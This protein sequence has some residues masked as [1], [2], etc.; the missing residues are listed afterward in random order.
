MSQHSELQD[1]PCASASSGSRRFRRRS[2][3]GLL[4]DEPHLGDAKEEEEPAPGVVLKLAEVSGCD[5]D[6]CCAALMTCENNFHAA[7]AQLRQSPT[8]VGAK[9]RAQMRAALQM[10]ERAREGRSVTRGAL[11]SAW[12]VAAVMLHAFEY[13]LPRRFLEILFALLGVRSEGPCGLL[14]LLLPVLIALL[15]VVVLLRDL[16]GFLNSDVSDK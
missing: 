1:S 5:L 16:D 6:T 15:A 12:V 9:V 4:Q 14:A 7:L 2:D 3:G 11:G 8:E 13:I 10:L